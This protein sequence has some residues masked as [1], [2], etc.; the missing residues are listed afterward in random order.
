MYSDNV[1]KLCGKQRYQ[2]RWVTGY[3]YNDDLFSLSYTHTQQWPSAPNMCNPISIDQDEQQLIQILIQMFVNL[4]KLFSN[5]IDLAPNQ[6]LIHRDV[7]FSHKANFGRSV[8]QLALRK[9]SHW[10]QWYSYISDNVV[11]GHL[12]FCCFI[13]LFPAMQW[14]VNTAGFHEYWY[15]CAFIYT[16]KYLYWINS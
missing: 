7:T 9:E 8:T 15:S 4:D 1:Y 11:E 3:V 10:C 16:R 6:F 14:L 2:K 12:V 13:T 5:E